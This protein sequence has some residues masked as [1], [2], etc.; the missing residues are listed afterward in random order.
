M[1]EQPQGRNMTAADL[2]LDPGIHPEIELL[3]AYHHGRLAPGEADNLAEHLSLCDH[4]GDLLLDLGEF[5]TDAFETD[6]AETGAAAS[7]PASSADFAVERDWRSLSARL[8]EERDEQPPMPARRPTRPPGVAYGLAA[9]FFAVAVGLSL[10]VL[11]LR[12][13]L[14]RLQAPQL[15]VPIVNLRPVGSL[16]S[17]DEAVEARAAGDRF[18][19][20]LNPSGE[21]A[22]VEHRVRLLR[23]D[24]DVWNE[25][26]S[27]TG[28]RPS[29]AGNFFLVLPRNLLPAGTY[30]LD[31][32][33]SL[34]AMEGEASEFDLEVG[35]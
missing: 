5:E 25:I 15:N 14:T 28:L 29:D 22:D 35:P 13:E 20:I 4:C 32:A 17:G 11:T 7:D 9:G 6:A 2:D 18:V 23:A 31:V 12:S 27:G 16:R 33:P 34:G 30:R 21:P 26:W 1:E 24:G 10:W 19:V 3:V 8:A